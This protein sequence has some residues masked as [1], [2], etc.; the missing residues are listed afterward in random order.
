MTHAA[1]APQARTRLARRAVLAAAGALFAERGYSATTIEAISLEA[2]V[3]QA[4]VYRLLSS[5]QSMLKALVDASVAGDDEPVPIAERPAVR[6]Q[7][8]AS[9]P[10]E[11][12]AGLA[13]I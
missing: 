10:R 5:K 13:A 9:D 11:Q 2:G 6:A 8:G 1:N 4:T 12:L 7:L 3:P